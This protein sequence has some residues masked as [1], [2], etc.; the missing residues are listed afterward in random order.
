MYEKKETT[1]SIDENILLMKRSIL[2]QQIEID[3]ISK[4][5]ARLDFENDQAN[6]VDRNDKFIRKII[7]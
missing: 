6:V 7:G 5:L 2:R 3:N 4:K 1:E